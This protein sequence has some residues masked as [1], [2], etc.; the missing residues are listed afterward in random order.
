RRIIRME[1]NGFIFESQS[2]KKRN[3]RDQEIKKKIQIDE[4]RKEIRKTKNEGIERLRNQR[5]EDHQC[6]KKK[7]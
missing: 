2:N 6:E 7:E 3:K 5:K 1:I 4:K